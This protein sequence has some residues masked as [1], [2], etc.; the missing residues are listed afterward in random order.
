MADEINNFFRK[1]NINIKNAKTKRALKALER[2]AHRYVLNLPT[3]IDPKLKRKAHKLMNQ[4]LRL[5]R[6]MWKKVS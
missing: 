1:L 6:K 5:I 3:T 4:S 2:M